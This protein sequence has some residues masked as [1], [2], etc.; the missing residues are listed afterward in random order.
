VTTT[1]DDRPHPVPPFAFL[2][3]KENYFFIVMDRERQVFGVSHL[4]NEPIFNRSR[5]SLN[6]SIRGRQYR[7]ASE[8]PL[9]QNFG[10]ISEL[11]DGKL[12]V[13][14]REPHQRFELTLRS[15]QFS[16]DILFQARRPTFDFVACKAAAPE[17]PSFQE[18]MTLGLNLPYNHQQQS[19]RTSGSVVIHGASEE[20]IAIDGLGYRDHS[21]SMRTDNI[22]RRHVWTGLNFPDRAFG[23][24]TIETTHRPGLWAKEGYVSDPSGERA[25][26]AIEVTHAGS[27]DGWPERT[28]FVVSDVDGRNFIEAD[29]AGRYADVPLHAE[30]P[31]AGALAY[32]VLETFAPL[33]LLETGESGIGLVEI[34][35]HPSIKDAYR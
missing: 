18:V 20:R 5:F 17:L 8:V 13:A 24:K 3:Y 35:R 19:L 27:R 4:N 28:R 1:H 9:P 31:A 15:E 2:R 29:I 11:T 21:W 33:K 26:R 23:I 14:F 34:G 10:S 30:K 22:S 6:L 32:E 16:A 12:T 7:Y 25:L